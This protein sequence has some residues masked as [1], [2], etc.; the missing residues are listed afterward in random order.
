MLRIITFLI[1]FFFCSCRYAFCWNCPLK[2]FVNTLDDWSEMELSPDGKHIPLYIHIAMRKVYLA[3]RSSSIHASGRWCYNHR[4]TWWNSPAYLEVNNERG[5]SNRLAKMFVLLLILSV[6][7]IWVECK[8]GPTHKL[9]SDLT[10]DVSKSELGSEL[11]K[12]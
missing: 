9:F 8:T 2:N 5:C 6:P 4:S 12:L 3:F 11:D 10:A 7:V 1:F